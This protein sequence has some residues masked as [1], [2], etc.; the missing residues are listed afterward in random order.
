[1]TK[2]FPHLTTT[3]LVLRACTLADAPEIQRLASDRDIASTTLRIPHPYEDGMAESWIATHQDSFDRGEGLSLGI[4]LSSGGAIIGN[5]GLTFNQAHD[6]AEMGYW[7]GKSYW[8]Q[9]YGTEAAAAVLA[10]AFESL[11]LNRVYAAHYKRNP[12][13][14]RIMQKIGMAYEG[15]LRQHVKKWEQYEDMEYYGILNSE[16]QPETAGSV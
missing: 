12:A 14:G 6:S 3:R 11:D 5:I 4:T 15:R 9:G 13:S 16:Y 8:N 10:Y 2:E 7:I 1:M